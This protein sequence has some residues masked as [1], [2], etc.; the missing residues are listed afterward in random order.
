VDGL[1]QCASLDDP[2][3]SE[4]AQL[5]LLPDS[6]SRSAEGVVRSADALLS[7]QIGLARD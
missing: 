3:L 6:Y 7:Q 5:I 1:K 2:S 4:H